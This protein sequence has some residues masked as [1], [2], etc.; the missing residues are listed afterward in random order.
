MSNSSSSD[1]VRVK[2]KL[3][4]QGKG[5]ESLLDF[6]RRTL[7]QEEYKYSQKII[8]EVGAP[9][10]RIERLVSK[11]LSPEVPQLSLHDAV[12]SKHMEEFQ[13]PD[14]ST[15][16]HDL[17]A[18]FDIVHAE[19]LEVSHVLIGSKYAFQD[20]L[21]I[22]IPATRFAVFGVPLHVISQYPSDVFVVC[23]SASRDSEP[24]DIEF[25]VKG[26]CYL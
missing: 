3:P 7:T 20:W 19:G 26:V 13:R 1:Y 17:W 12:R 23:G 6:L 14:N 9:Y 25:S 11:A 24:S 10:V 2:E 15:P 16:M 5:V 18:M 8:L 4:Y 21:K 22:R